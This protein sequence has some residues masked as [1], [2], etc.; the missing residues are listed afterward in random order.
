MDLTNIISFGSSGTS[1]FSVQESP[2]HNMP[3]NSIFARSGE[4]QTYAVE[5]ND[6]G[7]IGWVFVGFVL[8]CLLF[9]RKLLVRR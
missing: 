9:I 4:Y 8:I 5:K 7:F 1:G 3:K 2:S 6:M